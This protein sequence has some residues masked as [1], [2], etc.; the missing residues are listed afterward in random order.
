MTPGYSF[1]GHGALALAVCCVTFF[2]AP[3]SSS[4]QTPDVDALIAG[5]DSPDAR[6]RVVS[7]C[8]FA[9]VT[10]PASR[11]G[12]VARALAALLGDNESAPA[13]ACDEYRRWR[14]WWRGDGER[15]LTVG[16]ESAHALVRLSNDQ[17]LDIAPFFVAGASDESA[18]A[19]EN[20][21]WGLGAIDHDPSTGLLIRLLHDDPEVGV[22]R[23]AAWALGAIGHDESAQRMVDAMDDEDASV[24]E[25][26]A[27]ALGAIGASSSAAPLSAYLTDADPRVRE[28]V[29][30][31]LG[32]IGHRDAV[33]RLIDGLRDENADVR[34]QVAWALGAI[35]DRRAEDPLMDALDDPSKEVRKQVAWALSVVI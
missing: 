1:P 8:A 13:E 7:A 29:A 25:Q 17:D 11:A 35:G 31:A 21:A 6:E 14:R 2:L 12:Q 23:Q 9:A 32:A 19:R 27:W 33:P 20:S 22:R 5:L 15:V 3:S 16:K 34:A 4:A 24:R 28:Q 26:V 10:V 18:T 30:W